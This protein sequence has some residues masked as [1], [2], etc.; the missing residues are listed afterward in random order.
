MY[1]SPGCGCAGTWYTHDTDKH[2][3]S[4]AITRFSQ[5]FQICQ[6]FNFLGGRESSSCRPEE[7]ADL[8]NLENS[9]KKSFSL[10][11]CSSVFLSLGPPQGA[12]FTMT[13]AQRRSAT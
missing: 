5:S 12:S 10:C 11:P 3:L 13:L 7:M 2:G 1:E 6:I 9:V 8:T 4:D